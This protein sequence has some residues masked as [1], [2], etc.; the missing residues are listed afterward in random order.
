[1]SLRTRGILLLVLAFIILAFV[2]YK[3]NSERKIPI[4][5]S[6]RAELL[7]LWE[8][9]KINY[10][11]PDT[12]RTLDKQKNNIT[13]SEGQSYAM[14][15]AVWVDDK[16][17]FDKSWK[18]TQDNME[19]PDHLFSWLFGERPD[20]TYGILTEQNG[21]NTATDA[22]TD[23]ALALIFASARWNEASY[24]E[25]AQTILSAV[26]E[27]EIVMIGEKPY[28]VSNNV[29]KNAPQTVVVNPSYFAPYA[30]RIFAKIDPE[31]PWMK[32]V[33]TSYDILKR[34][35]EEPL[36]KATSAGL[37]PDWI[38]LDRRTGA[39]L[40]ASGNNLT[41]DMSFDALRV[42]WRLAID[43]KWNAEP[44]AKEVLDQMHFLKN[45]WR[46]NSLLYATYSHDGKP[47][48]R[49]QAAA[50]YG[51]TIGYFIVSDPEDAE[52]VYDNKLQYLFNPD[53][54]D[55]R[56][57]LGYY[58]DNWTW[59]GIALYNDFLTNLSGIK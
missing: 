53:W 52:A 20:G 48:M 5:F 58:D 31:H 6:P 7:A 49:N 51:G 47:L 46:N 43:W 50:F 1:M 11:E 3:N 39:I 30:Y 22:D 13:T 40:P 19:R 36:D 10:L 2:A 38:F 24:L 56:T 45:E 23:I 32:V 16:D 21:Q 29:E 8:I 17:I 33:D 54:N 27:N 9:Y 35:I 4:I 41:T 59:F 15:R 14:L 12:F 57:R 25:S 26:W 44:R 55:W 37:P 18:W 42:P 28:L 34:S